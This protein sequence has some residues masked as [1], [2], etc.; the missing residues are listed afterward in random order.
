MHSANGIRP[1]MKRLIDAAAR[2]GCAVVILGH[3]NKRGGA[4]QYR[5]LGSVDIFAAAR[6][7]LTV[8]KVSEDT[9]AVVHSKSNLAPAGASFAIGLDRDGRFVWLGAYDI[10]ADEL[11]KGAKK[12]ESQF[13]KARR[14]LETALA[15]GPVPAADLMRQAEEQGI[16]P[17][18]LKR[19]KEALGVLSVKRG[20]QWFWEL[21]IEAEYTVV[22]EERQQGHGDDGH[23][24][25]LTL[26]TPLTL[27]P[28]VV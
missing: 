24:G 14:L 7:V 21:P 11:L 22:S 5:G 16:S 2:T 10:T 26:S 18:T 28:E 19:A 1:L 27:F 9:R 25:A 6:S 12:P 4:A 23:G 3:L 17:K 8:G 13:T 15:H 20:V